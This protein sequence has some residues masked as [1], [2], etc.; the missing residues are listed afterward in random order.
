ML[1]YP[2]QNDSLGHAAGDELL[3]VVARRLESVLPEQAL[4]ARLG[5]DEFLVALLDVDPMT[6]DADVAAY[7]AAV[8]QAL[9]E[10]VV[11]AGRRLVVTASAGTSCFPHDGSSFST[12]LHAAD[13]RMYEAKRE[14]KRQSVPA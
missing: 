9:S 13:R 3:A 6:G 1:V 14:G 7:V 5:G 11:L 8:T 4:A 2:P 10:P 12:L